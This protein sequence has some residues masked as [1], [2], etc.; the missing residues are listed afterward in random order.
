MEKMTQTADFKYKTVAS[1]AT[2][3]ID[4]VEF[5]GT[6]FELFCGPGVHTH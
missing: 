5:K 1:K 4:E 3:G 2:T 6:Q